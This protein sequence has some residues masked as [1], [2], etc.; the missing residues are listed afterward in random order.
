MNV[1]PKHVV[2]ISLP[3]NGKT[4]KEI[5]S[6][7][8]A[9]KKWYL[10]NNREKLDIYDVA[11]VTNLGAEH[12]LALEL[13]ICYN[14]RSGTLGDK[15]RDSLWMLG[16]AL[17]TMAK[18]DEVLFWGKW[19]KARGCLIEHEAAKQY[20]IPITYGTDWSEEIR[21]AVD[22]ESN[23]NPNMDKYKKNRNKLTIVWCNDHDWLDMIS[24]LLNGDDLK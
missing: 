4:N 22:P 15:D 18:V 14:D 23:R 8:K 19:G 3:M 11:F 17:Q 16:A 13:N 10:C 1:K 5:S 24:D 6:E 9:A 12:D 7:V 20:K 2:F 21:K